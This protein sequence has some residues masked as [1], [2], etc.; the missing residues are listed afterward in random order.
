MFKSPHF[1]WMDFEPIRS[2][3]CSPMTLK[4][5]VRRTLD[6]KIHE[7]EFDA[8]EQERKR[9]Q[10]QNTSVLSFAELYEDLPPKEHMMKL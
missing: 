1:D 9:Q 2:Q 6:K 3:E 5:Y 4:R 8:W 10:P 7:Q